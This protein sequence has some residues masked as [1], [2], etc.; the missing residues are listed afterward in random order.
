MGRHRK[1][2]DLQAGNLSREMLER[3]REEDRLA[4]ASRSMIKSKRKIPEGLIDDRA[5]A[6]YRRVRKLLENIDV[7]CDLDIVNL[8]NYCNAFSNH[9]N[10]VEQMKDQGYVLEKETQYGPQKYKNPLVNVEKDYAEEMRKFASLCGMSIDS[11]L[12]AAS[13]KAAEEQD[14]IDGRFGGI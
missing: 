4:T 9:R 13:I 11:R 8:V 3:K 10:V 1:G 2:A 7:I 14:G 12:K 5:V 6:E